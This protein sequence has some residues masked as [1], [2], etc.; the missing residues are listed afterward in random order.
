MEHCSKTFGQEV[1]ISQNPKKNLENAKSCKKDAQKLNYI[2]GES[3]MTDQKNQTVP[4]TGN[5]ELNTNSSQSVVRVCQ[6][7]IEIKISS[8]LDKEN[9]SETPSTKQ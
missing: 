6:H 4:L 1:E 7:S 5:A 3:N 2:H 9:A 8:V